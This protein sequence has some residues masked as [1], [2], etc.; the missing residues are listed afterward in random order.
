MSCGK[1]SVPQGETSVE[2][3]G[4]LVHGDHTRKPGSY[5][6]TATLLSMSESS[7]QQVIHR[8]EV[9]IL[10]AREHERREHPDVLANRKNLVASFGIAGAGG[11]GD[12]SRQ[13]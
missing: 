11:G 2:V 10:I 6:L 8:D 3:A 9:T 7:Q 12:G 1:H 5:R 13:V 4:A